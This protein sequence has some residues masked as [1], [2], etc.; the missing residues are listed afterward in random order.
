MQDSADQV[1]GPAE[2]LVEGNA[3]GGRV[4]DGDVGEGAT[5]VDGYVHVLLLTC[6]QRDGTGQLAAAVSSSVLPRVSTPEAIIA[7]RPISRTA[8]NITKM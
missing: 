2:H 4:V 5:D 3:A 7:T 1:V 8:P 6:V